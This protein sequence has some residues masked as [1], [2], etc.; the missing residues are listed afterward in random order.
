[1]LVG[2]EWS[3][4]DAFARIARGDHLLFRESPTA[5]DLVDTEANAFGFGLGLHFNLT[6]RRAVSTGKRFPGKFG[7]WAGML[8]EID[9]DEMS[10]RDFYHNLTLRL[11]FTYFSYQRTGNKRG[12]QETYYRKVADRWE[13][14]TTR[15][16]DIP[17]TT[18]PHDI[19]TISAASTPSPGQSYRKLLMLTASMR[20]Q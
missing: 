11:R 13:G 19:P 9:V 2:D 1:M 5:H 16:H 6:E 10:G 3:A 18:R 7:F 20:S 17:T 12:Y 15:P 8:I 14:K 4:K